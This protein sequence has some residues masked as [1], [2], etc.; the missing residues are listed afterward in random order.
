MLLA[1]RCFGGRKNRT[2]ITDKNVTMVKT[3]MLKNYR[4]YYYILLFAAAAIT[5]LSY[6]LVAA[7][8][9]IELPLEQT[10]LIKNIFF[11]MIMAAS[12][13]YSFYLKKQRNKLRGID[14]FDIKISTHYK[15][16][17]QRIFWGFLNCLLACI[18][19]AILGYKTF[20]YFALI[21]IFM[22]LS[23]FPNKKV[24]STELNDE[25]IEYI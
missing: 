13:G 23:Q 4:P 22:V 10:K 25:E 17:R 21:D 1:W 12:F 16:Y 6:F 2:T 15:L 7:G 8:L 18:L 5:T 20:F 9:Y 24:F 3:V 11:V 14:D 19:F